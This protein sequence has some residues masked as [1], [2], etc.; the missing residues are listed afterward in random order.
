MARQMKASW[1]DL[2]VLHKRLW[3]WVSTNPG[4]FKEDWPGWED[5]EEPM[6]RIIEEVKFD[7]AHCF[8]CYAGSQKAKR[9]QSPCVHCPIDWSRASI[10][11][12]CQDS[13][14]LWHVWEW[15]SKDGHWDEACSIA[16]QMARLPWKLGLETLN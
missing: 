3:D 1:A 9:K 7:H 8:A 16:R 12:Q 5:P 14:S 10:Q 11:K 4:Y 2:Q 15:L 13:I 6:A